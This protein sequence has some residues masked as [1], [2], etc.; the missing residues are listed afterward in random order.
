ML[1]V[2][3]ISVAPWATLPLTVGEYTT[4]A[5]KRTAARVTLA[6]AA[7]VAAAAPAIFSP[8]S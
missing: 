7:A 1:S 8:W 3:A 4:L 6:K 2:L 5:T